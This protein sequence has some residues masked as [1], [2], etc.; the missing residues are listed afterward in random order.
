VKFLR[1][2]LV[3]GSGIPGEVLDDDLAIACG[4][5]A[6][7]PIR[8]QRAGKPAMDRADF[9]RGNPIAKGAKFV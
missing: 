7:R 2:E 5:G 8:L 1:A 9:L 6:L 4:E 3:E